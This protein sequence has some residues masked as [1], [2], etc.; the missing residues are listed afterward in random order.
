[1]N[2]PIGGRRSQAEK[3][4]E[5]EITAARMHGGEARAKNGAV[6]QGTKA[7]LRAHSRAADAGH[8]RATTTTGTRAS[9][10]TCGSSEAEGWRGRAETPD[11]TPH[12]EING[13]CPVHARAQW[14]GWR[15]ARARRARARF[16]REA[17]LGDRRAVDMCPELPDHARIQSEGTLAL[18]LDRAETDPRAQTGKIGR[19]GRS[20]R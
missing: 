18:E 8:A 13:R 19:S 14:T 1:M 12:G 7:L 11:W 10:S 17:P 5:R 16:G 4:A 9:T 20:P 2:G 6:A 15:R 3:A